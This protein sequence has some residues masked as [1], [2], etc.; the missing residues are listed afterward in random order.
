MIIAYCSGGPTLK[1]QITPASIK[2]TDLTVF[3]WGGMLPRKRYR[4]SQL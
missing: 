4:V 3:L 2:K 1:A